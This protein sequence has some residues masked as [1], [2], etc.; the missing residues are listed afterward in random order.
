LTTTKKR[1][2]FTGKFMGGRKG[3]KGKAL[4]PR[5]KGGVFLGRGIGEQRRKVSGARRQTM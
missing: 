1:Q 3:K 5:K 2:K 4:R